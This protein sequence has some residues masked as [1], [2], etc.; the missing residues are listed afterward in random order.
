MR[1]AGRGAGDPHGVEVGAAQGAQPGRELGLHRE[2]EDSVARG[3]HVAAVLR[4]AH[5]LL[6]PGV[7]C[8]CSAPPRSPERARG[9]STSSDEGQEPRR[10][11]RRA[12]LQIDGEPASGEEVADQRPLVRGAVAHEGPCLGPQHRGK[13]RPGRP[14]RGRPPTAGETPTAGRSAGSSSVAPGAVF[15]SSLVT[16]SVTLLSSTRRVGMARPPTQAP[17]APT[18]PS[19]LSPVSPASLTMLPSQAWAP[20]PDA[21]SPDVPKS[22]PRCPQQHARGRDRARR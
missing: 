7:S 8:R 11:S 18:E 19:T 15:M 17:P 6:R 12:P 20:P 2:V 5:G 10:R 1:N 13:F 14:G 16:R 3:V 21:P 4:A 9:R 22:S